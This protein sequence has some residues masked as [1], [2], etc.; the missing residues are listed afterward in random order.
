M[1]TENEIHTSD[2]PNNDYIDI[3][4]KILREELEASLLKE[5]NE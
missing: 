4:D 1:I 2:Y 3:E 5:N